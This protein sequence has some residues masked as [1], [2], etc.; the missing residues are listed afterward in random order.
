MMATDPFDP[1][2]E[3]ALEQRAAAGQ[4]QPAPCPEPPMLPTLFGPVIVTRGCPGGNH[5]PCRADGESA[6]K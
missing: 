6:A 3:R 2:I 4:N 5:E 1:N